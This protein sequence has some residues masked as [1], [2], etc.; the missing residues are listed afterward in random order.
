VWYVAAVRHQR[1]LIP[2]ES[3]WQKLALVPI[4]APTTFSGLMAPL[5]HFCFTPDGGRRPSPD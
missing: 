3:C 5:P 4:G 2:P 1:D